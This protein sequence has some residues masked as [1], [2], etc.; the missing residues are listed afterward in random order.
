MAHE[1]KNM[2]NLIRNQESD[3]LNPS[4]MPIYTYTHWQ[5]F[6]NWAKSTV[7]NEEPWARSC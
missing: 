6:F 4:E 7:C 3:R 1:H 2:F 5:W